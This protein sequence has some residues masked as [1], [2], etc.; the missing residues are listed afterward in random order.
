MLV[1][2]TRQLELAAAVDHD[3]GAAT[4]HAVVRRP[5][6]DVERV[7]PGRQVVQGDGDGHPALP[8]GLDQGLERRRRVLAARGEEPVGE[9]DVH[10]V[11]PVQEPGRQ[12]LGT[13]RA[14]G[15]VPARLG[16]LDPVADD[17][18]LLGAD[19]EV[20]DARVGDA[21]RRTPAVR[22]GVGAASTPA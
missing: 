18:V 5:A 11:D 20:E 2:A 9:R 8:H 17:A 3:A 13:G 6:P 22:A 7:V 4:H 15:P 19:D 12:R 16:D 1:E 14:P 10:D 21:H